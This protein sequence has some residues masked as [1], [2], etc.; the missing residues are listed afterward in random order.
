[1]NRNIIAF[2]NTFTPPPSN[3]LT[4]PEAVDRPGT[5]QT[6]V[7]GDLKHPCLWERPIRLLI[8]VLPEIDLKT[9]ATTQPDRLACHESLGKLAIEFARMCFGPRARLLTMIAVLEES[10][11]G[12]F[13]TILLDVPY[14]ASLSELRRLT[15]EAFD[16]LLD[17]AEDEEGISAVVAT[18]VAGAGE[19]L[20][21]MGR[22]IGPDPAETTSN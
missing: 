18:E 17:N 3:D 2:P 7:I 13:Y 21:F 12:L 19:L 10:Q 1:M 22:V 4:F 15:Y 6:T 20:H 14:H 9:E 11:G 16:D 8:S 5:I